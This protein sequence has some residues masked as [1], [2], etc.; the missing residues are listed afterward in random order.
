[1]SRVT[2]SHGYLSEKETFGSIP[3]TDS[4]LCHKYVNPLTK[5]G[6]DDLS[7]PEYIEEA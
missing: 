1:M 5:R 4:L 7:E 3:E 2:S 6:F